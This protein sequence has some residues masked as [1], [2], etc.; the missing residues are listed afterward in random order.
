MFYVTIYF[1]TGIAISTLLFL[2]N[3]RIIYNMYMSLD[4]PLK[5]YAGSW[6][7]LSASEVKNKKLKEPNDDGYTTKEILFIMLLSI[8]FWWVYAPGQISEYLKMRK[9]N[10][11]NSLLQRFAEYRHRKLHPEQYI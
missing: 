7:D 6:L 8:I 1:V 11:T 4:K 3:A 5:I 9:P 2:N 10:Q